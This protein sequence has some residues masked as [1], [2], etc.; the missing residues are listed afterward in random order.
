ML[1]CVKWSFFHLREQTALTMPWELYFSKCGPPTN[2]INF[3][4][5]RDLWEMQI[6]RP[7]P[8]PTEWETMEVEPSYLCFNKSFK[9]FWCMFKR[10]NYCFR[11]TEKCRSIESVSRAIRWLPDHMMNERSEG[12]R[13][14]VTCP[15]RCRRQI[16]FWSLWVLP[17]F[18]QGNSIF[19]FELLSFPRHSSCSPILTLSSNFFNNL[20]C[21]SI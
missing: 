7:H 11:K 6:L 5:T 21:L 15:G 12:Q 8:W 10:E 19:P 3:C 16:T 13:E 9:R 18:P 2:S 20:I 14:K 1:Q 4:T 17:L